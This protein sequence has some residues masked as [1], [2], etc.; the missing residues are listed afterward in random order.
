MVQ[1][2]LIKTIDEN[3]SLPFEDIPS[4]KNPNET[5]LVFINTNG[6]DLVT[7]S[8]SLNELYSNSK[9]QQYNILILAETNIH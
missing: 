4:A 2:K 9:S 6:L 7:D 3:N 1:T 8:H 5:R